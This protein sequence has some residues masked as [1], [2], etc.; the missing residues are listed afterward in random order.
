MSTFQ[1]V[2]EQV[3]VVQQRVSTIHRNLSETSEQQAQVIDNLT[4]LARL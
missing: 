4:E 1:R 2:K 3:A